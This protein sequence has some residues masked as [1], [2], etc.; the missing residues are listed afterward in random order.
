MAELIIIWRGV[1]NLSAIWMDIM[2]RR[3][4]AHDE[5][6][7]LFDA[8]IAV[9]WIYIPFLIPND[10]CLQTPGVGR[11]RGLA[12]DRCEGAAML[13]SRTS[14]TSFVGWFG[15]ITLWIASSFVQQ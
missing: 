7:L 14:E 15:G 10:K 11:S 13:G 4:T 5:F 9:L 2:V 1:T 3:V 8:G 12:R 6:H